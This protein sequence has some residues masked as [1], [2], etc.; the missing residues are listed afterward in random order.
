MSVVWSTVGCRCAGSVVREVVYGFWNPV[1][2]ICNVT[3]T[4]HN[5]TV[6]VLFVWSVFQR[7]MQNSYY[8]LI[9]FFFLNRQAAFSH[10][11]QQRA[12][13]LLWSR[14]LFTWGD[15][16]WGTVQNWYQSLNV[17]AEILIR[18]WTIGAALSTFGTEMY[19]TEK[20]H[21][22]RSQNELF[23]FFTSFQ[24]SPIAVIPQKSAQ[25]NNH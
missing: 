5:T 9:K 8:Q 23:F 6:L 14:V 12:K 10:V 11:P 3:K 2:L 1:A 21:I 7:M 16:D 4:Y 15:E 20:N 13:L 25:R 19:P 22:W 24:R 18:F 17:S